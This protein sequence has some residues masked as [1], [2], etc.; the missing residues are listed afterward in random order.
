MRKRLKCVPPEVSLQCQSRTT[1]RVKT[2]DGSSGVKIKALGWD[3]TIGSV[4]PEEGTTNSEGFV[5]FE[6]GCAMAGTCPGDTRVTFDATD[7]EDI[8]MDLD[9]AYQ[10]TSPNKFTRVALLE[11]PTK[12]LPRLLA[13]IDYGSL[14]EER[15]TGEKS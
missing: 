13:Q 1:I 5:E 15:R 12:D 4:D 9:C 10:G 2:S 11:L 8:S 3:H 7:Y 14:L 6:V